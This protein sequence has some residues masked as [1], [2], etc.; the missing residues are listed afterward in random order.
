VELW[1][2]LPRAVRVLLRAG[3]RLQ[4]SGHQVEEGVGR[5]HG[6]QVSGGQKPDARRWS[7]LARPLLDFLT[8]SARP[9]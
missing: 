3:S 1:A 2:T 8:C 6:R 7:C 9:A 5:L 4:E